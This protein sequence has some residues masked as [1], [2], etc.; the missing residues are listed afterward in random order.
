M[1]GRYASAA[2]RRPRS[3][4]VTAST[5]AKSLT[6]AG[7]AS[8]GSQTMRYRQER[9]PSESSMSSR[10]ESLVD[11]QVRLV[12]SRFRPHF[13]THNIFVYVRIIFIV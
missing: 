9:Q 5:L 10:A 11:S 7:S 8:D 13:S 6:D 3:T 12:Q 4:G 2:K 1:D